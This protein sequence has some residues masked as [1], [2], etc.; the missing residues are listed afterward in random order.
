M[1]PLSTPSKH[2]SVI[3]RAK[4]KVYIVVLNQCFANEVH[5]QPFMRL[6]EHLTVP[7]ARGAS[8]VCL[9]GET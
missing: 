8:N 5:I 3:L 2:Q 9:D 1:V 4:Q 6:V 7:L